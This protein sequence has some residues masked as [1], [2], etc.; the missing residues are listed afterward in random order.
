M[1]VKFFGT[2]FSLMM[3]MAIVDSIFQQSITG[4]SDLNNILSMDFVTW[5]EFLIV[6]IPVPDFDWFNSLYN[7][8]SFNFFFFAGEWGGQFIRLIGVMWITGAFAWAFIVVILPIML[9]LVEAT[10]ATLQALNPFS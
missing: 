3:L 7:V 5:K 4:F 9:R 2:A 6:K 8:L 10:A 1:S